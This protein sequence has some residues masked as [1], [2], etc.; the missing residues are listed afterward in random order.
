MLDDTTI[1]QYTKRIEDI[2]KEFTEQIVALRRKGEL[3]MLDDTKISQCRADIEGILRGFIEQAEA[4][5]RKGELTIDSVEKLIA[6]NMSVVAEKIMDLE[7]T[8]LA[9]TKPENSGEDRHPTCDRKMTKSK[10]D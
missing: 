6:E 7:K 4:Q 3:T 5:R 10:A 2:L 8:L 1:S 9:E